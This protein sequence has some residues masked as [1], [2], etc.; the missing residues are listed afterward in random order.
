MTLQQKNMFIQLPFSL[1]W[2]S[3]QWL[4]TMHRILPAN[5]GKPPTPPNTSGSCFCTRR[6]MFKS[7][8]AAKL[9]NLHLWKLLMKLFC[10]WTES[11]KLQ[12]IEHKPVVCVCHDSFLVNISRSKGLIPSGRSQQHFCGLP[13]SHMCFQNCSQASSLGWCLQSEVDWGQK[14]NMSPGVSHPVCVCVW[15]FRCD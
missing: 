5:T 8:F 12:F 1:S 2:L 3:S 9:N 13:A 15:T 6:G 7:E 14:S 4:K 10:V 11:V